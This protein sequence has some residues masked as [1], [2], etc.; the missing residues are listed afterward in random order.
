MSNEEP[1]PV[2]RQTDVN[3]WPLKFQAGQRVQFI[4]DAY[5]SG[6]KKVATVG[7]KGT[8]QTSHLDWNGHVC[9]L[10]DGKK[11]AINTSLVW[12]RPI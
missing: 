1:N 12:M 7:D 8:L 9:V 2:L 11:R 3:G 10:I 4:V 5:N 6:N